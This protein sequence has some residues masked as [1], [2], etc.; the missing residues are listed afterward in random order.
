MVAGLVSKNKRRF[1]DGPHGFD[2]DLA[3]IAP[4]IIA[5]GL[6][7]EGK[8]G[9]LLSTA[10]LQDNTLHTLLVWELMGVLSCYRPCYS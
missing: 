5:M 1:Q 4:R 9:A 3:Y 10:A 8:D 7:A 6:P 2:L